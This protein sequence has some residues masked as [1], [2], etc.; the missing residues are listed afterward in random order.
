[1]SLLVRV[2]RFRMRSL[3]A[4]TQGNVCLP[5]REGVLLLGRLLSR[6]FFLWWSEVH[7]VHSGLVLFPVWVVI[8]AWTRPILIGGRL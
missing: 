2:S 4:A 1:M 7:S 5:E 8:F 6:R 3:Q